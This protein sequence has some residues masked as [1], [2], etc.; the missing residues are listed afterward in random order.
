[1]TDNIAPSY[2]HT[3]RRA[4]SRTDTVRARPGSLSARSVSHSRSIGFLWRVCMARGALSGPKRRVPTRAVEVLGP[5]GAAPGHAHG[6]GGGAV[7][8][9]E[10]EVAPPQDVLGLEVKLTGLAQNSQADPAV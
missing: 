8:P 3:G 5:A 4:A 7:R 10:G 2:I 9:D 1:M 6:H